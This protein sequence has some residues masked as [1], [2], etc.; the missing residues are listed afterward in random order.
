MRTSKIIGAILVVVSSY[1]VAFPSFG[2]AV[3]YDAIDEATI[4][5][6]EPTC[7]LGTAASSDGDC[8]SDVNDAVQQQVVAASPT[9]SNKD[10]IGQ[11][12]SLIDD[13]FDELTS[14]YMPSTWL[15]MFKTNACGICKK[16]LPVFES[17]SID[18][19][20]L[21]HNDRELRKSINTLRD[22]A[23]LVQE[24]GVPSG[25]IYIS[26]IDAASWSS[27]DITKRFDVEATPTIIL[28]RNEGFITYDKHSNTNNID[29]RSYYIY[30]EQRAIYPLR[31][32]VLGEFIYRKRHDI[33]PLLSMEE[34]KVR[35]I[36]GRI[37]YYLAPGIKWA[38]GIIGKSLLVW[39]IFIGGLGIFL[40][41]HNYAWG[42]EEDGDDDNGV[43][44]WRA[45]Q[46]MEIEIEKAKGR[47]EWEEKEKARKAT[48]SD[49]NNDDNEDDEMKGKGVSVKKTG[50]IPRN[51]TRLANPRKP[52]VK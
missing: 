25:P 39:F 41:V 19:D 32:F 14:T 8:S 2:S 40:R 6:E 51:V 31:K 28:I 22:E 16:A 29:T 21:T 24:G 10:L 11:V 36:V 48:N 12:V 27:S 50:A 9:T 38:G 46:E 34:R 33:P 37:E 5:E 45:Q 17:L 47:K 13:N 1:L 52:K 44:T 20:I 49:Y 23:K 4:D 15:V 3:S 42:K 26:T 43:N 35:T 30:K 18:T 7:S